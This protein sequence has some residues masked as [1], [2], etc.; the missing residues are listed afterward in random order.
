MC[1]IFQ[2]KKPFGGKAV[3]VVG[4]ILQVRYHYIFLFKL[5]QMLMYI[6]LFILQLRPVNGS[7]VFQCPGNPHFAAYHSVDPLWPKFE[8]HLL[9]HNHRQGEGS[10][11]VETLNRI[12]DKTFTE[13]DMNVL[14]ERIS[15]QEFLEFDCSHVMYENITVRNHN[16]KMLNLLPGTEHTFMAIKTPKKGY[17]ICPKKGTVDGTEFRDE[18][19]LKFGARVSMVFNVNIMDNLVN[20]MLGEVVGFE[21]NKAGEI[22]AVIVK[23]D[24]E[25]VGRQQREDNKALSEKYKD[26]NGTPIFRMKFEYNRKSTSKRSTTFQANVVQFPLKLGWAFTCHSMQVILSKI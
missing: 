15:P 14:R 22:F 21:T 25:D 6:I 17:T 9:I 19:K 3:G 12:R 11:W 23:F 20:G 8:P 2:N 13:D 24:Q 26:C 1:Q 16:D 10:K 7:Y 5:D 18:L 4:D